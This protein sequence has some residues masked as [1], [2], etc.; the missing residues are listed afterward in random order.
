MEARSILVA[1]DDPATV[2][3]N[4]EILRHAGHRV[5]TAHT[6]EDAL[7]LAQL[8]KPDVVITDLNLGRANDG[9]VLAGL[10]KRI[11]PATQV[12][13]SSGA[14]DLEHALRDF[15]KEFDATLPKGSH[16]R[17]LLERVNAKTPG[18]RPGNK[19]FFDLL[20]RGRENILEE[21]HQMVES[22]PHLVSLPLSKQERMDHV[23]ELLDAIIERLRIRDCPRLGLEA[24]AAEKHGSV[25]RHQGYSLHAWLAETTVFRR[26]LIDRLRRAYWEIDA[27]QFISTLQCLNEALDDENEA[28]MRGWVGSQD[29]NAARR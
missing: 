19:S 10:V 22:D 25:R 15:Q 7:R 17:E 9:L 13:M 23:G 14:P 21:W 28:S 1:D 24:E 8:E 27:S 12:I 26:I 3:L 29:E 5:T 4:A 2:E 18:E 6:I 20:E 11:S 16:P